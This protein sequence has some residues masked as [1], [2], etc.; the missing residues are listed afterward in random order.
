MLIIEN[1]DREIF[2]KPYKA[3]FIQELKHKPPHNSFLYNAIK[4]LT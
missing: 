4:T 2:F 3:D 1:I